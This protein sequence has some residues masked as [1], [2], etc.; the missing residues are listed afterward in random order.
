MG[1]FQKVPQWRNPAPFSGNHKRIKETPWSAIRLTRAQPL[2]LRPGPRE[3]LWKRPQWEPADGTGGAPALEAS[4]LGP[5]VRTTAAQPAGA[6]ARAR[7]LGQ[8][9]DAGGG[10]AG[11][12]AC[13]GRAHVTTPP[14]P[15]P[16]ERPPPFGP[17]SRRAPHSPPPGR[18][19]FPS[20]R[21]TAGARAAAAASTAGA[22]AS[23]VTVNDEVIKVFNDMKVR[24]S[25]TQ[26]EIKKRKKAVL[27]C[28]SDDKRQI[29]VEEAKQILVGDI[30]DTVEDPYTSFV[31]LLPLNDCR[32]AL[33]DATYETKESK[34]EDLVFIFWAPESAPLKSKM[35]YA[36]SKDAIKKKF[37]GIKHEWQVNGLDDIKDRS[38]LG[39]KLGGN[40]VVSLEGKPL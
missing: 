26:E 11:W 33:Y 24:K 15:Q 8:A 23:G 27:F 29:I 25:S 40:V 18:P 37:T 20:Q 19:S 7:A 22:M 28:L 9:E 10:P 4:E 5:G 2:E 38:T 12:S 21:H 31:K 34:K 14:S 39:E 17:H 6:A 3:A 36:S 35:I 1:V 32:Y 16:P 30:G 13:P